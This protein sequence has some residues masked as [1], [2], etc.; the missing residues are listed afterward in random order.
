MCELLTYGSVG[1]VGRKPGPYPAPNPAIASW[2]HAGHHLRGAGEPERSAQIPLW[3]LSK[4]F[5]ILSLAS[6]TY[7]VARWQIVT[8]VLSRQQRHLDTYIKSQAEQFFAGR[9]TDPSSSRNWMMP[10]QLRQL[11]NG[12]MMSAGLYP[13]WPQSIVPCAV[14]LMLLVGSYYCGQ[15]AAGGVGKRNAEQDRCTE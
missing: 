2:L 1:G 11:R 15:R 3:I 14:G 10:P 8:E 12:I 13:G 5:L 7:G 4:I 9:T 6:V